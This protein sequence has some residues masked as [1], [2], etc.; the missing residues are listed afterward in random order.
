M[1]AELIAYTQYFKCIII[2]YEHGTSHDVWQSY[3]ELKVVFIIKYNINNESSEVCFRGVL[4]Y[5]IHHFKITQNNIF[6][7]VVFKI[8]KEETHE[9]HSDETRQTI[10]DL[11]V[12]WVHE[13]WIQTDDEE[14][15]SWKLFSYTTY[16]PNV[17]YIILWTSHY[18]QQ[19][20]HTRRSSAQ[21]MG[22]QWALQS[23]TVQNEISITLIIQ[24][25]INLWNANKYIINASFWVWLNCCANFD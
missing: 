13:N 21:K 4:I 23:V 11:Y 12:M 8:V 24:F 20:P 1:I 6:I 10:Y 5:C 9:R 2:I 3:V 14:N 7:Y 15:K 18:R 19:P 25:K 17:Y 22:K 16:T